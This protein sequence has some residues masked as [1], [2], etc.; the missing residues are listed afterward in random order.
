MGISFKTRHRIFNIHCISRE[1]VVISQEYY[2][3]KT[4]KKNQIGNGPFTRSQIIESMKKGEI[5]ISSFDNKNISTASIDLS[6]SDELRIPLNKDELV[7]K[8]RSIQSEKK[9]H[10]S[11]TVAP[12]LD[13]KKPNYLF[14]T[15]PARIRKNSGYILRP[16]EK[17]IGITKE[18]IT[19]S[20]NICC[21]IFARS[22]I[23]R[24]FVHVEFAPF[25]EP[26]VDNQTVLEIKNDAPWP[27]ALVPGTKI[28]KI[29]FF[30][31]QGNNDTIEKYQG[32][33][34][35][36]K[37]IHDYEKSKV[38]NVGHKLNLIKN[39]NEEI[40]VLNNDFIV[41]LDKNRPIT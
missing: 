38:E 36:Q 2:I 20:N 26:N 16:H 31:A 41:K 34:K 35:N 15:K 21:F 6:L 7:E 40:I 13:Q 17:L 37:L 39:L 27:I 28:C 14:F 5:K 30:R 25:I 8:V 4:M 29:I 24:F 10:I 32:T 1:F 11:D 3:I 22:S 33:Y 12:V 18:K 23:A 9:I 19:L